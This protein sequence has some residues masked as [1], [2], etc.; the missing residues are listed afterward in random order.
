[1][2]SLPTTLKLESFQKIITFNEVQTH[3]SQLLITTDCCNQPA[4]KPHVCS[5]ENVGRFFI[6]C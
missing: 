5:N 2:R 1:M 6:P 3:A 4:T